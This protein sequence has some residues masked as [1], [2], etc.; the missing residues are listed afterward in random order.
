MIIR[1]KK[2]EAEEYLDATEMGGGLLFDYRKY[3]F[4]EGT[5]DKDRP[6][7]IV[8][9]NRSGKPMDEVVPG[10]DEVRIVELTLV[11]FHN[12]CTLYILSL[13]DGCKDEATPLLLRDLECIF[14]NSY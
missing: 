10:V 6:R 13:Q 7:Y 1:G 12:L 5:D 11:E 2:L 3:R 9:D 8:V 4:I 14:E